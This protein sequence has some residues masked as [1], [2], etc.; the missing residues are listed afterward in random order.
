MSKTSAHSKLKLSPM[1][2]LISS[3][4]PTNKRYQAILHVQERQKKYRQLLSQQTDLNNPHLGWICLEI[5]NEQQ[6]EMQMITEREKVQNQTIMQGCAN[7]TLVLLHK[8]KELYLDAQ[9]ISEY[10][11]DDSALLQYMNSQIKADKEESDLLKYFIDQEVQQPLNPDRLK[12]E[13]MQNDALLEKIRQG[14]LEEIKHMDQSHNNPF[15]GLQKYFEPK[16]PKK[17]QPTVSQSYFDKSRNQRTPLALKQARKINETKIETKIPIVSSI[18]SPLPQ[19]LSQI[20]V[21]EHS[22]VKVQPPNIEDIEDEFDESSEHKVP[23]VLVLS[24]N[25][26]VQEVEDIDE[27]FDNS[28]QPEITITSAPPKQREEEFGFAQ[29]SVPEN[30]FD[31]GFDE[32]EPEEKKQPEIKIE[33]K[34]ESEPK[35]EPKK[36]IT[37]DEPDDFDDGF[38]SEEKE[39]PK[40]EFGFGTE[41]TKQ[42]EKEQEKVTKV[43]AKPE[44]PKEEPK[45]EDDF[46]DGFDSE[47]SEEKAKPAQ[48]VQEPIQTKEP[49]FEFDTSVKAKETPKDDFDFGFMEPVKQVQQPETKPKQE[50]Q[51]V[52]PEQKDDFDFG[53]DEPTKQIAQDPIIETKPVNEAKSLN[54]EPQMDFGFV[55]HDENKAKAELKDATVPQK[56]DFDFGFSAPKEKI[57]EKII[58]NNTIEKESSSKPME[59]KDDFDFGFDPNPETIKTNDKEAEKPKVNND[60]D[61][62]FVT[63]TQPKQ[64]KTETKDDFNFDFISNSKNTENNNNKPKKDG[65]FDD[66]DFV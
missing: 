43:E 6:K 46:D 8:G 23:Q 2:Q 10:I 26:K 62:D 35:I 34:K 5:L 25:T 54:V 14:Q 44:P 19:K 24:Q 47:E 50:A 32:S 37:A 20:K 38:D 48:P 27:D 60:F 55:N 33:P 49:N 66:F 41:E 3:N 31:D 52:K 29:K 57:E 11:T 36:E 21:I 17:S 63:S 12:R 65:D 61:F 13:I 51:P 22:P 1:L 15:S 28:P 40:E 53:F 59:K 30:D 42:S 18:K 9:K 7:D 45:D 58:A 4:P 39:E 64:Q 56:D 16:R